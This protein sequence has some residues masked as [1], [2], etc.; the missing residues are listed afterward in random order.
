MKH[1]LKKTTACMSDSRRVT[2]FSYSLVLAGRFLLT[3][4]EV[5]QTPRSRN[6]THSRDI[7]EEEKQTK[8]NV[9]SSYVN[10]NL[11]KEEVSLNGNVTFSVKFHVG[12][13]G[14]GT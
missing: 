2:A 11:K 4:K 1:Y 14:F 3:S 9:F 12:Q 10:L 6:Y 5:C 8:K 7:P 13:T